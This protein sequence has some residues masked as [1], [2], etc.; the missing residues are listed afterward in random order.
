MPAHYTV[1]ASQYMRNVSEIKISNTVAVLHVQRTNAAT[2]TFRTSSSRWSLPWSNNSR[3]PLRDC[4]HLD[5]TSSGVVVAVTVIF[6]SELDSANVNV[7]YVL[8]SL[9]KIKAP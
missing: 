3:L 4:F 2:A 7:S 5:A 6:G 9:S 8:S 1:Q